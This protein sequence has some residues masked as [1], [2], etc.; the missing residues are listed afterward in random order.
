MT[1][2]WLDRI[3]SESNPWLNAIKMED[4][5]NYKEAITF[6]LKDAAESV[7]QD[8]W[9]RAALSF[10][11]AAHCYK[12]IKNQKAAQDLYEGVGIIYEQCADSVLGKSIR[13][14]LW[15]LEQ[16]YEYFVLASDKDRAN[17]VYE[18]YAS[19][20]RKVNPFLGSE[21]VMKSLGDIGKS[22]EPTETLV[23]GGGS[24]EKSTAD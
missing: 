17:R 15:F 11:C 24:S 3:T 21:Q 6:Y 4:Q 8:F 1:N 16:S 9:I 5:G 13:E 18:K 22:T 20:A 23:I 14:S 19:L 10:S 2:I 12:E 7:K